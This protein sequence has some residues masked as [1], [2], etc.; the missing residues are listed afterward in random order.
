MPSRLY[1]QSQLYG[2]DD[3][4]DDDDDHY[5]SIR[6]E[7]PESLIRSSGVTLEMEQDEKNFNRVGV[8]MERDSIDFVGNYVRGKKWT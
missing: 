5:N 3:D 2:N 6:Y 4:D 8:E 1:C 7:S